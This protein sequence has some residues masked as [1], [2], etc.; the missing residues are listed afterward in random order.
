[1]RATIIIDNISKNELISEWGLAVFI[2][3]E[4]QKILLDTGATGEFV[5]NAKYLAL[6]QIH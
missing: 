3:Y 5:K 1:M 2:E 6:P 4:G